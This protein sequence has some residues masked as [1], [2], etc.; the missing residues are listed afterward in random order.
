[1]SSVI[2]PLA[3]HRLALVVFARG[4]SRWASF[5]MAEAGAVGNAGATV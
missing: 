2:L 5:K 1:L 3:R 4:L